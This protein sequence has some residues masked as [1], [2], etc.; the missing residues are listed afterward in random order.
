MPR[1]FKGN[2]EPADVGAGHRYRPSGHTHG[3]VVVLLLVHQG[4]GLPAVAAVVPVILAIPVVTLH[5]TVPEPHSRVRAGGDNQV[6]SQAHGVDGR[7]AQM[8]WWNREN[9]KRVVMDLQQQH[10]VSRVL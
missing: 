7:G 3:A 6:R 1:L 2:G 5:G 4:P 9:V 8:T 10:G